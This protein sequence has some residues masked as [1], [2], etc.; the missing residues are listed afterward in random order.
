MKHSHT[1]NYYEAFRYRNDVRA[2]RNGTA[3][4]IDETV[5]P[6]CLMNEQIDSRG[7]ETMTLF[8]LSR[9]VKMPPSVATSQI[10]TR[11]QHPP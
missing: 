1:S 11:F 5:I 3:F 9:V 7:I 6:V 8:C 4:S 10:G 2:V